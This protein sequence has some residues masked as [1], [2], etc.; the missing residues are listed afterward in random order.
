MFR[1]AGALNQA[2]DHVLPTLDDD[3]YILVMD[4]D[5]DV[6][7][8]FLANV[9]RHFEKDHDLGA[10]SSNHGVEFRGNLL[11]RLQALEFA[12]DRRY[13]GRK[14]GNAGCCMSGQGTVFKVSALRLVEQVEGQ[15][16]VP[17]SWTEDW[18]LTFALKHLGIKLLKPADCI[19]TTA[20]VP[21]LGPLF[22]QRQRW[23]RGYFEAIARYGFT[24]ITAV[25]WLS[26]GLWA[27]ST[28][29]WAAWLGLIADSI[30]A[31]ESVHFAY[32][33]VPVTGIYII[34]RVITVKRLGW[35]AM[36][37]AASSIPD[38]LFAYWVTFATA[39]GIIKH[40]IGTEGRWGQVRGQGVRDVRQNQPDVF[41]EEDRDCG[42]SNRSLVWS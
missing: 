26:T 42:V 8:A 11:E 27:V 14:Q 23:G 30:S 21:R 9:T 31:G 32:W 6:D 7:R 39:L 37:L 19:V 33:V 13:M 10:V 3:D 28:L 2:L 34:S 24:R 29:L 15:I 25:P 40:L 36:L 18:M 20:P 16:F 35:K 1:K 17:G 12:R 22:T 4:A 5:V 41:R 38:I